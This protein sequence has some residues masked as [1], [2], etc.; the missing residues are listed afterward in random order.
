M[1]A[2]SFFYGNKERKNKKNFISA[3]KNDIVATIRFLYKRG[4]WSKYHYTQWMAEVN[5]CE[6]E[7]M[8][9]LWWDSIV[10]GAM[11]ETEPMLESRI[12]ALEEFEA[13]KVEKEKMKCRQQRNMK[14]GK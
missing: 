13:D 12:E 2:P 1:D 11:F 9:H 4:M 5:S 10:G 8:L 3:T 14:K 6:D 7:E